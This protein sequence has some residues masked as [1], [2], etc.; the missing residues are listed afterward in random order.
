MSQRAKYLRY[1]TISNHVDKT[2]WVMYILS[3]YYYTLINDNSQTIYYTLASPHIGKQILE[4][5]KLTR[6]REMEMKSMLH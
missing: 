6:H 2:I 5:N 1:N 4:A 3:C